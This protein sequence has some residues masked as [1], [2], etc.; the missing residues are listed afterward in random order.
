MVV[1]PTLGEGVIPLIGNRAL[2]RLYA[3]ALQTAG[4]S[5]EAVES[6]DA[7]LRGFL[8]LHEMRRG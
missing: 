6:R 5:S 8:A 1:Y 3:S 7:C 4:F 2:S